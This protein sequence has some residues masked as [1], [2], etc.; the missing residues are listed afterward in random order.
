MSAGLLLGSCKRVQSE[1][2]HRARDKRRG[3][4][5]RIEDTY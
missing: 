1:D 2:I 3:F 4:G 5:V